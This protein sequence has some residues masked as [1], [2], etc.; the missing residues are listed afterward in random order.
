[1]NNTIKYL[2]I[3]CEQNA[4]INELF[5]KDGLS[6]AIYRRMNGA[7]S[8]CG[9]LLDE[10]QYPTESP[11]YFKHQLANLV[12]E[13]D[14]IFDAIPTRIEYRSITAEITQC[15][16]GYKCLVTDVYGNDVSWFIHA[17]TMPEAVSRA[18]RHFDNAIRYLRG[19]IILPDFLK[20]VE[21]YNV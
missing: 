18:E 13:V 10:L 1:M 2:R 11:A 16:R 21:E 8:M 4:K 12:A 9:H 20:R 7:L 5:D 3:L 17:N 14:A 19:F 6:D 15:R